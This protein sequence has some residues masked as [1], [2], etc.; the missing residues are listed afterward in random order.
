MGRNASAPVRTPGVPQ[1]EAQGAD[2]ET[3]IEKAAD[4]AEDLDDGAPVKQE[5]ITLTPKQLDEAIARGIARHNAA[6]ATAAQPTEAPLPDE[7]DVD[8]TKI[9]RP[10][11]TKSGY[12][13]PV[14]YGEPAG[15]G[16][17]KRE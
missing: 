11:L 14:K 16:A 13:V 17:S 2:A 7:K 8:P 3:D 6:I 9:T 12:V 1:T 5:F 10:T 15:E 4:A